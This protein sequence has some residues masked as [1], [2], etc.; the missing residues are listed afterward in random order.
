MV[1]MNNNILDKIILLRKNGIISSGTF[2][3]LRGQIKN[4]VLS[5]VGFLK[6]I[7]YDLSVEDMEIKIEKYKQTE[8]YKRV[9][10]ANCRRR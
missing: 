8:D 3:S 7:G 2:T 6:N 10:K 1:S 4:D 9:F 5:V